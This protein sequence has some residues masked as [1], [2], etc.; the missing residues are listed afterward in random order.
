VKIGFAGL[1]H[2]GLVYGLATAEQG[3]QVHGF[4]PDRALVGALGRGEFS[5]NEPGLDELARKNRP[6]ISWQADPGALRD[7]TLVF[8]SLDV[9]TDSRD[10]SDTRPLERLMRLTLPSLRPGTAVVLLSQVEPG[11]SRRQFLPLCQKAGLRAFYQVETLVF[12]RAVER[13]LQPERFVVGAEDPH[14]PLPESLQAWHARFGGPVLVMGLESAELCKIA[15]NFFLVS[16]ICTTNTLAEAAALA[17]ADWAEIAPALRLDARIGPHA[18]L[19]PGLGIGG[20]N[21]PRDLQTLRRLSGAKSPS[22]ALVDA[23]HHCSQYHRE[24]AIRAYRRLLQE[25]RLEPRKATVAVWGLAYKENTASLKNSPALGFL[26]K[27]PAARKTVFDPV[28]RLPKKIPRVHRVDEMMEACRG[29]DVLAI[30]TP[31]NLFRQADPSKILQVMKRPLVMDPYRVFSP[32]RWKGL[33]AR[34]ATLGR[35]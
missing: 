16:S 3:F 17:G 21:L 26:R 35:N 2:L 28:A 31:W 23:W 32:E 15:I 1:S 6:R 14:S 25:A 11:F 13:A 9:A 4:D 34:L 20:G 12:G 10:R 27:A 29:A 5:V 8:L 33:G 30:L 24:W 18:Y 7:C 19:H 22:L